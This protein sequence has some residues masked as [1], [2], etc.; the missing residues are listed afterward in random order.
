MVEST[1]HFTTTSPGVQEFQQSVPIP[2]FSH[3]HD[4]EDV[5]TVLSAHTRGCLLIQLVK[6]YLQ[7]FFEET[8]YYLINIQ[9]F[10]FCG[11]CEPQKVLAPLKF[12]LI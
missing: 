5:P 3:H 8:T 10:R 6:Q 7:S 11:S 4:P 1:L 9:D 12:P 2:F